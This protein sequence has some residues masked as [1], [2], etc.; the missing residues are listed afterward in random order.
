MQKKNGTADTLKDT[1]TVIS[2]R[3]NRTDTLLLDHVVNTTLFQLPMG[4]TNPEDTLLF[5]VNSNNSVYGDVVYIKKENNPH[6]E[7][8]DC[9]IAFF[10]TIT[11]IR[12]S[13]HNLIDTIIIN[14][15]AVN[16]D[17]STEHFQIVFKPADKRGQD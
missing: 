2:R 12:Q 7:S 1:L 8:V 17:L 3:I 14:K 15:R 16:Y 10:H 11:D 9:N 6:F 5:I 13:S 4:Y